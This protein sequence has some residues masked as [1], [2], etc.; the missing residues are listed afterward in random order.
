MQK[1]V[2]RVML[3]LGQRASCREKFKELQILTAPSLYNLKMMMFV[4]KNPDEYQTNDKIHTK[5][6]RPKN[7]LPPHI[8]QLCER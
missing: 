8:V 6:T 7:Q 2:I 4:I 3:G 5:D 1:R